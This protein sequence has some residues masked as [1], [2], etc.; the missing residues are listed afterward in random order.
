MTEIWPGT[1]AGPRR[2]LWGLCCSGCPSA[3]RG[4]KYASRRHG[5]DTSYSSRGV[6]QLLGAKPVLAFRPS[7]RLFL[8]NSFS[9]NSL[10]L[11]G[12]HWHSHAP[13]DRT[14]NGPG[15]PPEAVRNADWQLHS[16]WRPWLVHAFLCFFPRDL[17]TLGYAAAP[18]FGCAFVLAAQWRAPE[19]SRLPSE[20]NYEKAL[21]LPCQ[22][23]RG[24]IR[25][26]FG[27]DLT[28][29]AVDA[30]IKRI[31]LW[32]LCPGLRVQQATHWYLESPLFTPLKAEVRDAKGGD[33]GKTKASQG[34]VSLRQARQDSP[35]PWPA[36]GPV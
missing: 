13:R 9:T 25:P 29:L 3:A 32:A 24:S 1:T 7:R 28:Q 18:V 10:M 11:R 5:G 27:P 33:R 16:C 22:A 2:S 35:S 17:S 34:H 30:A 14:R 4:R 6:F 19:V 8:G 36:S 12:F 31:P 15:S 21:H 20:H 23:T 26:P